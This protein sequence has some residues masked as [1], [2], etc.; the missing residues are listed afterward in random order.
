MR[1]SRSGW[2]TTVLVRGKR[3]RRRRLRESGFHHRDRNGSDDVVIRQAVLSNQA[4]TGSLASTSCGVGKR[5]CSTHT[6][7]APNVV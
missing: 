2:L 3:Q 7:A 6:A 1:V 5:S 4:Q